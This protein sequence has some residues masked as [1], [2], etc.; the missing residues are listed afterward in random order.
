MLVVLLIVVVGL[1]IMCVHMAIRIVTLEQI[2]EQTILLLESFVV[3]VN[4]SLTT[5]LQ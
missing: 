2:K 1:L 4:V 3:Y 5:S